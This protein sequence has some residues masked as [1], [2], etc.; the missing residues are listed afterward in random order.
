MSI[1]IRN[2]RVIDPSSKTDAVLDVRVKGDRVA[3]ISP[4]L[5]AQAGDE[6]IDAS[7]YLVTPGLIDPHVHLR[8]PGQEHKETIET[9]A[10]AAAAGGFTTVCCMPNTSP[11]LDTPEM[12]E[13][14]LAKGSSAA[15]RVFPVM[16]ATKGRQGEAITE[17]QLGAK[18]GAVGVSD[19]GDVIASASMMKAVLA[20][21]AAADLVMM[22]HAQETTLTNG[23]VM[24][25]GE[26]SLRL[27]LTGWPREAEEIIVE[28]DCRL[29]AIT[30]ARYHVQHVSSAGTV[31]ILKR[32]QARGARVTGEAS[33][34]HLHLTHHACAGPDGHTPTPA[35]KMNPP[36]REQADVDAL[37]QAV[38]D[39]VLTVL[40]TDHAPHTADEK[41]APFADAPFGIIGLELALPLYA[42]ALVHSGLI[43]WPRLIAL[44][45]TEPAKLCNLDR[46]GLGELK[47]GGPADITIIDPD[48]EWT[49]S[50]DTLAGKSVNTPFMVRTLKARAI[51]T[52]CR[53]VARSSLSP[54]GR[55]PG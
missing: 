52:I 5:A 11:A 50:P 26:V 24:H 35:A 1:L 36:L 12:L 27:G 31:E 28:R 22:Q 19:D 37:R 13:W 18:A 3:D 45:T 10:R 9:G 29:A 39:D 23:S 46:L 44:M 14:V 21:A 2:G 55:G 51:R 47:V 20:E 33:P 41:N 15:C 6:V 42:E 32:W 4:A 53:G 38:A 40:A 25:A 30:G 7:G 48:A 43:D 34:H 8:E 49:V 16:A 17:I 54:R